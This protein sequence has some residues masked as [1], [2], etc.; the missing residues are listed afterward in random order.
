MT[1]THDKRTV[2]SP[3]GPRFID[4]D[5]HNMMQTVYVAFRSELISEGFTNEK[6]ESLMNFVIQ[7]N[8]TKDKLNMFLESID[9]DMD[10]DSILMIYNSI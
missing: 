7:R 9:P 6:A 1:E 8:T 5:E 2:K 4:N 3:V 10:M